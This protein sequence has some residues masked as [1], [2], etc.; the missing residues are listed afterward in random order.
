MRGVHRSGL[1]VALALAG[2]LAPGTGG[3]APPAAPA[4][5]PEVSAD[6]ARQR[7]VEVLL[8]RCIGPG[9]SWG[10]YGGQFKEVLALGPDVP[11]I[12]LRLFTTP[13]AVYDFACDFAD[14]PGED[15]VDRQKRKLILQQLAGAALGA[16]RDRSVVPDLLTFIGNL[17][18][19]NPDLLEAGDV[20]Q[21]FHATA[22]VALLK[23]GEPV[24]FEKLV[25]TLRRAAGVTLGDGG[26][27]KVVPAPDRAGRF[28]QMDL[29]QRLGMLHMRDDNVGMA[30][31][32]Y[33]R[34][35]DLGAAELQRLR[36]TPEAYGD[37]AR[38]FTSLQ[39]AHYNLACVF[40]QRIKTAETIRHL[41]K[42]VDYGYIDLDWIKRDRD[43]D[44]I[45][46]DP[47]YAELVDS[48]E[49]RIKRFREAAKEELEKLKRGETPDDGKSTPPSDK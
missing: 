9:L 16:S 1:L 21:D 6:R 20:Q 47:A 49:A 3:A 36:K 42:A 43:L 23:L 14:V 29:L 34:S 33:R 44:V 2:A 35:I 28:R 26:T 27:M 41:K 8:N 32:A 31:R 7:Q 24:Y 11:R 39:L 15:R 38:L 5:A 13:H 10:Y 19:A 48:V 37:W 30:E 18:K 25:K 12:L 40:A 4:G 22:A 45:R 46:D 17:E